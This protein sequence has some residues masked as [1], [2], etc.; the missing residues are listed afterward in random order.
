MLQDLPNVE[1]EASSQA[2]MIID[3][4]SVFWNWFETY[5]C[6]CLGKISTH[7]LDVY[8]QGGFTEFS[9][10]NDTPFLTSPP[11]AKGFLWCQT[12]WPDVKKTKSFDLSINASNREYATMV[13]DRTL[14]P[15]YIHKKELLL[16][17]ESFSIPLYS[18]SKCILTPQINWWNR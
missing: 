3:E 12:T 5:V 13:S 8:V 7:I 1:W 6:K 10:W 15:P 16:Y 2:K 14:C 4:L 18:S 17:R 9:T 11:C